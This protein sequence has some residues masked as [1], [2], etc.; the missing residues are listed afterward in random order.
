[1]KF[2]FEVGEKVWIVKP[3]W[4]APL[5]EFSITKAHANEKFELVKISNNT[6]YPELVEKGFLSR[7]PF[8][9]V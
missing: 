1:V 6:L 3:E 9:P 8:G 7:D 5:G 2:P 4:R